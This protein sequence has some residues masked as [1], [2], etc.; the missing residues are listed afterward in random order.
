MCLLVV[1]YFS[2]CMSEKRLYFTSFFVV[3]FDDDVVVLFCFVFE[4]LTTYLKDSFALDRSLIEVW[5]V[6]CSSLFA[7]CCFI[8]FS[9]HY[10]NH[11]I[12]FCSLFL[13][14]FCCLSFFFFF[15]MNNVLPVPPPST[16]CFYNFF[17]YHSCCC[18]CQVASVVSDSVWPQSRQPTRLPCP[19]DSP[20]KSTGVGCHCLIHLYH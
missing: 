17:L 15:P 9:F 8:L 7:L 13:T 4:H 19:W 12:F 11:T 1:N 20:G 2:L 18:C 6:F 10:F 5:S 16:G 14:G 3:L